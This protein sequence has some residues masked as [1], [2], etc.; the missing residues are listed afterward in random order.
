MRR[1][2]AVRRN[3][4]DTLFVYR[5]YDGFIEWSAEKEDL[6]LG[7]LFCVDYA[8][9]IKGV[10]VAF[11]SDPVYTDPCVVA[12]DLA[13]VGGKYRID[14]SE[15]RELGATEVC[16]TKRYKY[17]VMGGLA[18]TIDIES[19]PPGTVEWDGSFYVLWQR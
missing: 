19:S 10:W 11:I 16:W 17:R 6:G 7:R 5:D 1:A 8:Q 4:I 9:C 14:N 12:I 2:A 18:N 15:V 3:N 13:L